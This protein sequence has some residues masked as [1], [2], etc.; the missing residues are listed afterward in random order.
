M[1]TQKLF[2]WAT[3]LSI[4]CLSACISCS[5][6]EGTTETPIVDTDGDGITDSADDCPTQSGPSSNQG[7]PETMGEIVETDGQVTED[8][9][10]K[11][12]G[13]LGMVLNTR[14]IAKKG[15]VPATAEITIDAVNTN[16]SQTIEIDPITFMG[17]FSL[18]EEDLNEDAIFELR[19][20]VRTTVIVRNG[21][22]D[23][24]VEQELSA[25]IFAP[26]PNPTELNV[27]GLEDTD[28]LKTV[29]L[30][31]NTPYY[32]QV[33]DAEGNPQNTAARV[34]RNPGFNRI[35]TFTSGPS[36]SGVEAEPDFVFNFI[37]SPDADEP[38]TYFIKNLS[39]GG[40]FSV[41]ENLSVNGQL[42]DAPR[43]SSSLTTFEQI[44]GRDDFEFFKFIIQRESD[45]VYQLL[46]KPNQQPIKV[47]SGIGFVLGT[48]NDF[49][50]R[51]IATNLEWNAISL[52]TSF[53][54]PILSAPGTDFGA[55]STLTNCGSGT[56]SQTVGNNEEVT[57][58]NTV[59]WEE[60]FSLTTSISTSIS[61]TVETEISADFFGAS[62]SQ[63]SSI[64]SEIEASVSA[65]AGVSSF[66]GSQEEVTETIFFERTVTVPPGRAS[67]VFD[68]AQIY[69]NT[70]IQFVQRFRLTATD[71]ESGLPLTGEELQSQL[72]FSRFSG[73]VSQI[74]PD[75]IDITVK[76]TAVLG[77]VL[78]AMSE[79]QD[80]EASCN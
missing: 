27:A 36:F 64:T 11:F 68:V 2:L 74:G 34:N 61:A 17:Q 43:L 54:S 67:L 8:D 24:I 79:V 55:N 18:L 1:K 40:F 76:G 26:N 63:S 58:T 45:G 48:G 65:T 30:K 47:R 50:M 33:V 37:P 41:V 80:I 12:A 75:F 39:D 56:L 29:A 22:G 78:S 70:Q 42:V 52:G 49:L 20:G 71:S 66:N 72:Q 44:E 62:A 77:K 21:N 32:M 15:F 19:E 28:A 25:A 4:C 73:V 53:L 16:F 13:E 31:E 10:E 60:S 6:D 51:I 23:S 14:N 35:M 7:C 3:I 46:S 38:N 9:F 69:D 59:S 5:T 57:I